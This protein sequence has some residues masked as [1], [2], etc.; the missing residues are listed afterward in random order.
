MRGPRRDEESIPCVQYDVGTSLY[1][2][3]DLADDDV[4]D[5]F[6]W[7]NVPSGLDSRRNQRLHLHDLATWIR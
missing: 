1:H 5:L 4:A 6:S 2:H 3:L 7:M